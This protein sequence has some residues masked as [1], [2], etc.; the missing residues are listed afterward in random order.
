[1]IDRLTGTTQSKSSDNQMYV[2][3]FGQQLKRIN[4]MKIREEHVLYR[5]GIYVASRTVANTGIHEKVHTGLPNV[6]RHKW[7]AQNLIQSVEMILRAKFCL[8]R[9]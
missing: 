9:R 4:A 3:R 8:V 5:L 1:M 2:E 7:V 6:R